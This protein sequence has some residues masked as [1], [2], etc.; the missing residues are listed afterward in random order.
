MTPVEGAAKDHPKNEQMSKF[1]ALAER[2]AKT[3]KKTYC[4]FVHFK[5]SF[6]EGETS[7]AK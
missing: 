6:G 4:E 2:L 5:G 1:F 3:A 7:P